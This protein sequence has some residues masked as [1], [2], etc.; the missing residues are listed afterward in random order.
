MQEDHDFLVEESDSSEWS[1]A[2]YAWCDRMVPFLGRLGSLMEDGFCSHG[3]TGLLGERN[4]NGW[5]EES[6]SSEQEDCSMVE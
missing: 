4:C 5:S 3:A 6:S 1:E 2:G